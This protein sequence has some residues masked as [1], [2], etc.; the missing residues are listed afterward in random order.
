MFIKIF[1]LFKKSK[2]KFSNPTNVDLLVFDDESFE[3]VSDLFKNYNYSI[4]QCR[5]HK[6]NL[7]YLTPKIIF[8]TFFYYRGNF[9]TS[10]LISLIKIINPKIVFTYI[11]NSLKFSEIAFRFRKINKSI[12]F[13]ALQ[14]GARYEY[15]EKQYLFKKKIHKKNINKK[16]YIPFFLSFGMFEKKIFTKLQ[17]KAKKIFTVGSII[18]ERYKKFKKLKQLK[19]TKKKRSI[20]LL[21]DHGAWHPDMVLADKN[22]EKKFILLTEFCLRFAKE[23]NYKI[24]ICEKRFKENYDNSTLYKKSSYYLEKTCYRNNLNKYYYKLYQ[25]NLVKRENK[26]FHTYLLMEESDVLISTMSTML[27]ENLLLKNKVFA[28][29]LTENSVYNFPINS[30]ISYNGTN[31]NEFK[32]KLLF[33]LKISNYNYFKKLKNKADFFITNIKSPSE[34]IK[35]ILNRFLKN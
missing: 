34:T 10:Y 20:C 13:I 18:L 11:D 27:R 30:F 14:N 33:V 4:I 32:K 24:I 7:L 26:K 3:A 15:L 17:I 1:N 23:Y 6:V 2:I 31:Y 12:K 19:I 9:F 8:Y 28:A 21:S 16:I 29:N 22:L 25:K 5:V 35:F